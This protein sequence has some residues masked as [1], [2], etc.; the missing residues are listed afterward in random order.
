MM[1]I[2]SFNK[3]GLDPKKVYFDKETVGYNLQFLINKLKISP[4]E[5]TIIEDIW[6]GGGNMGPCMEYFIGGLEVGNMV[7]TKYKYFP[8]GDLEELDMKVIDVGTGLER[9]VWMLNGNSTSYLDTFNL[10]CKY[11]MAKLNIEYDEELWSK[12]GPYTCQLNVDEADDI[13]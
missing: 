4:T 1:G 13:D 12:L 5:I 6:A 3:P 8:N 9:V 10:S 7:F 2:Q 11:L